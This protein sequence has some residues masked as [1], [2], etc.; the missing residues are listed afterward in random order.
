MQDYSYL[1]VL[2]IIKSV[3][4][5]LIFLQNS[6]ISCNP[7]KYFFQRYYNQKLTCERLFLN[8]LGFRKLKK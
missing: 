1:I 3:D 8:R 2:K 7:V 5:I 4:S 6:F